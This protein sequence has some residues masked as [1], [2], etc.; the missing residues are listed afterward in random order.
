MR[1][2]TREPVIEILKV[3]YYREWINVS[4]NGEKKIF[5]LYG[6]KEDVKRTFYLSKGFTDPHIYDEETR[7]ITKFVDKK[8]IMGKRMIVVELQDIVNRLFE[9]HYY[10]GKHN[11]IEP[12][13]SDTFPRL[14]EESVRLFNATERIK[15]AVF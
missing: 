12:F 6:T 7:Q 9:L 3:D 8:E 14:A 10:I 11:E 1:Q 15:Q 5:S 4:V 13:D 2:A